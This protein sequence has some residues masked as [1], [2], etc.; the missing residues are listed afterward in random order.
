MPTTHDQAS[1]ERPS[2]TLTLRAREYRRAMTPAEER[3]WQCLRAR[4]LGPHFRRQVAF[5]R[6]IADFYAFSARLVVEVDGPVHE[7][8]RERDEERD[9]RLAGQDLL[10]LRFTNEEVLS[11]INWVKSRIAEACRERCPETISG[12]RSP[13]VRRDLEATA[14]GCAREA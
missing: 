5:R 3:L 10:V 6:A 7:S 8:R 14:D 12:G 9:A 2:Q 13:F 4:R 1:E 11:R